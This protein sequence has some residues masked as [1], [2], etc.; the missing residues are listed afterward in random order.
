MSEL[1]LR[2]IADLSSGNFR[3]SIHATQRTNDRRI[4]RVDIQRAAQDCKDVWTDDTE[5][6]HVVGPDE[7]GDEIEVRAAYDGG[8]VV[9]TIVGMG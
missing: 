9:I 4:S 5:V 2:I 1:E 7:C 3:F 6:V 8:T